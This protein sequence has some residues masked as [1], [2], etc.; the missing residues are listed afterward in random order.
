MPET[1][2]PRTAEING[3]LWGAAARDWADIQEAMVRTVYHAVHDRTGVSASTHYLDVGC[4]SGMAATLASE[5]GARISGLDAAAPLLNIARERVPH[6]DFRTGDLEELPFADN[7]FDVVTG[8]NS[9]QYAGN[10][11]IALAEAGRVTRSGGTIVV[12][13]WGIPDG[14][15]AGA[16]IGALK[17][18]LPPPPPG[19]PGPFALSDETTLRDFATDAGLTPVEVFD[20]DSPW[21]YPDKAT[22]LRGLMATGVVA[23]ALDF[24]SKVEITAAYAAALQT[25]RQSDGSYYIGATYRCLLAQP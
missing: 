12:M 4:G 2:N 6:G 17:P 7:S 20:V 21:I 19:A 14:M 16:V 8:F 11:G 24:A 9:F 10:P 3:H 18:L 23:R 22:A 25:F 13:T 5:R 1:R 15:E